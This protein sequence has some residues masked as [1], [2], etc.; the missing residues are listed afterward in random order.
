MN[1]KI[2]FIFLFTLLSIGTYSQKKTQKLYQII[3][4]KSDEK[5]I[6]NRDFVKIDSLGN[7]L[8]F[9]KETGEKVNLKSFNKALT[10][11]VTE[12]SEV[13]KI[14]GSNNFSPLTVMP[15]KGQYSFGITIIFLEDYHNEKE[16]KTK[17]EYKWTSVSDTNQRELFF[18][19][20]SK[21]DKLVMEK[22]LD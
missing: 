3:I 7:I 22:F 4:S 20:L 5:D 10:K 6:K 17:T 18:K 14:P 9:N 12:E 11:F 16:F 8:S 15:G 13:K 2:T 1:I 19:Y 21:E